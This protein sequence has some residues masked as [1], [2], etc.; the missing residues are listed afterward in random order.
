MK[1]KI[2][3]LNDRDRNHFAI[4][5]LPKEQ[6]ELLIEKNLSLIRRYAFI[7]HD[8]D[9]NLDGTPKE[10]H[11]HLWISFINKKSLRQLID[12][13][14]IKLDDGSEPNTLDEICENNISAQRYLL[15]LDN[16]EKV[17]YDLSEVTSYNVNLDNIFEVGSFGTSWEVDA[18]SMLVS[19]VDK[20]EIAKKYGRDFIYHYTQFKSLANDINYDCYARVYRRVEKFPDKYAVDEDGQ[21]VILKDLPQTNN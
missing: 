12:M 4:T 10:P 18:L 17:Q 9:I 13:L 21:L 15:H 11:I 16:P 2:V 14:H 8:R 3:N 7:Y 1:K 20:F 6:L 5:Y 19:G